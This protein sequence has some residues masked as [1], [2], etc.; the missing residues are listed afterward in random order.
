MYLTFDPPVRLKRPTSV[1]DGDAEELALIGLEH[2]SPHHAGVNP[3]RFSDS[4]LYSEV[5][6]RYLTAN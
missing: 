2:A 4:I 5:Q 1:G 6:L 3:L